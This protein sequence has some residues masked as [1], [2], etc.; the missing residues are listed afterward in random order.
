MHAA[1]PFDGFLELL[2]S[3]GYGVSLHEH[4]ALASLLERWDRTH[5]EE[6]GDALAALVAR[7]EEEVLGIRR[8]FGEV[9]LA[10]PLPSP[11]AVTPAP[12]RTFVQRWM[13]SLAPIAAA[14]IVAATLW[15]IYHRPPPAPPPPVETRAPIAAAG[16]QPV[17]APVVLPPP[18]APVLPD[19]PRRVERGLAAEIVL[20][21][22]LAVLAMF[23]ALKT[24]QT[25]RTWLRDTWASALAALPGPYHFNL[26]LRDPPTRLP[27]TDVE[28]AATIL[29]RSFT[30]DVQARQ[31]DVPR[32]LRLTLRHGL[33]PQLVFR[34]RR[35]AQTILVF[36]DVSQEMLIWRPKVDTFLGDLVRQGVPL[37]RWY[38]DGDP[39]RVAT[40]RTV[41]RAV[42]SR[43]ARRPTSPV[44]I[45]SAGSG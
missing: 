16:P 38:F 28:D 30:P 23:W 6:F 41:R 9:Y 1:L 42:R 26:I 8:L 21:A 29:G 33:L 27:R 10:P 32:S 31:L 35:T 45:V 13:W 34:P 2:R 3:K 4:F 7:N 37:E 39:R 15:T 24:R 18:P 17:L 25:T 12:R 22:F 5:A 36:Q 20:A 11:A 40:V 14:A 19:P 44:L 43:H